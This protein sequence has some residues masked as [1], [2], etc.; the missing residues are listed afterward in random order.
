MHN[1]V[2]G[3]ITEEESHKAYDVIG[4]EAKGEHDDNSQKKVDGPF[5][6]SM[7]SKFPV[8]TYVVTDAHTWNDY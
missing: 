4:Q 2:W 1:Y 3:D 8:T 7:L 5:H 6:S